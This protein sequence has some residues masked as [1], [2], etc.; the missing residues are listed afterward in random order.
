MAHHLRKFI[1][2]PLPLLEFHF[3]SDPTAPTVLAAAANCLAVCIEVSKEL[4]L[5]TKINDPLYFQVAPGEDFLLSFIYS[6]LNYITAT[7]QDMDV[8]NSPYIHNHSNDSSTVVSIESGL[9]NKTDLEKRRIGMS[10]ISV[11]TRLALVFKR[12]DVSMLPHWQVRRLTW[13]S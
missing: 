4:N 8:G 12:E 5:L 1:T 10:T 7:N 13:F 11:I 6:L 9:R 2:A 3:A